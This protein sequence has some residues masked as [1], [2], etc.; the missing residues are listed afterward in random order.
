MEKIELFLLD[1][2]QNRHK[3]KESTT[4]RHIHRRFGL[5]YDDIKSILQKLEQSNLVVPYFDEKYDEYR[6]IPKD[7]IGTINFNSTFI[8]KK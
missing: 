4:T 5:E 6:Y 3:N 2:I 8:C 1:F 7:K